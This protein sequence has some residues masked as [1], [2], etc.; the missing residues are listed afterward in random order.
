[1]GVEVEHVESAQQMQ[2]AVRRATG[3]ADVVVMAAA[4]AD[5]RPADY[6]ASKI[7]KAHGPG[8]EESA[9]TLTL[10][11]NPD[12]L[13]GLVTERGPSTSPLIVGFAA[14]TGD[15]EG[16][17]IHHARAKLARKGC[18]LLVAN[19]VGV[20]VTFGQDAST[21]HLLRPGQAEPRTVGPADKQ[22]TAAAVWDEVAA[23]MRAR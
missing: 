9:P 14:E 4:V 21:I 2:E 6:A 18:D 22:V 20:G 5:F 17:V 3:D 11:R 8:A 15:D 16:D 7:K 10:V 19:E 13:A 23:M 1:V 12:I